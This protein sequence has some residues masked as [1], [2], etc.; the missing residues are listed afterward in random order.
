MG[1]G[2]DP[3]IGRDPDHTDHETDLSRANEVR[4]DRRQGATKEYT[5]IVALRRYGGGP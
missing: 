1:G 4:S 2:G 5:L 3:I